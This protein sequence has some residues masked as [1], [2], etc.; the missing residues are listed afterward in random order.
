MAL[1]ELV[2][3]AEELAIEE[4]PSWREE[5]PPLFEERLVVAEETKLEKDENK[6]EALLDSAASLWHE[7]SKQRALKA[8]IAS[9]FFMRIP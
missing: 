9:C 1:E 7:E 6:L 8:R 5:T 2:P 3:W 4:A